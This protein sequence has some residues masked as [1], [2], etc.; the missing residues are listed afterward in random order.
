[1]DTFEQTL[2]RVRAERESTKPL[3]PGIDNRTGKP[4]EYWD[5]IHALTAFNWALENTGTYEFLK[6]QDMRRCLDP[7]NAQWNRVAPDYFKLT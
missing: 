2:E 7:D 4:Y 6:L 3:Q 5:Y 1:M